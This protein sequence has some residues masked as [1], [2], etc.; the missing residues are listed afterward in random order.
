MKSARRPSSRGF[1]TAVVLWA[2][3]VCAILVSALQ[4]SAWRQ[5]AA[6]RESV[7]RVRAFWAARAGL[8]SMVA[9][10]QA[11]AQQAEPLS[12]TALLASLAA[13]AE[14]S[15]GGPGGTSWAVLHTDAAGQVQPG[16]EDAA[17]RLNINLLTLEDLLLLPDMTEDIAQAIIDW[18]TPQEDDLA[19]ALTATGDP[20]AALPAPYKPRGG[21]L[22]DLRELELIDGVDPVLVRGEDLN[23]NGLLDPGEDASGDGI[24]DRGWS[25]FL[26]AASTVAGPAPDGSPR[27]DLA[28]AIPGDLTGPLNVSEQQATAI[29]A[30]AQTTSAALEDFIRTDLNTLYT[31]SGAAPQPTQGRRQQQVRIQALNREQTAALYDLCSIGDPALPKPGK[32]NINTC[33][34]EILEYIAVVTPEMRDA[35]IS[36][37]SQTGGEIASI[38]D[39]YDIPSMTSAQLAD[40]AAIFAPR[41]DVFLVTSRGRDQT[42][43]IEVEVSAEIDRSALPV[44]IRTLTVR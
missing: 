26:T 7:G 19:A 36:F 15:L 14:G 6:A 2:L 24:L 18:S 10:L 8:E 17:A 34:D 37:R 40:L 20:Y 35:L 38:T 21:P 33:S 12:T 31:R 1:A 30:H 41:S 11:E 13:Q 43:G 44:A 25:E 22:R 42:T 28:G 32:V 23:F 9:R 29:I 3:G 27:I 16:P 4:M 5:S 39:L